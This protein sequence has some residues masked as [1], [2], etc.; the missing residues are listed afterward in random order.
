M[1]KLFT[2]VASGIVGIALAVGVGVL[3][4][5]QRAA[6]QVKAVEVVD[7]ICDFTAKT[8]GSNSYAAA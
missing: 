4:N 7:T 5:G 2:K 8:D 3:A 6:K 1:K